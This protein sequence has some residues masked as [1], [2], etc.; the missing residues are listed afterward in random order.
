VISQHLVGLVLILYTQRRLVPY[1]SDVSTKTISAGVMGVGGNKGAVSVEFKFCQT[2]VS[3]VNCHLAAHQEKVKQRNQNLTKISKKLTL[4]SNEND[5]VVLMGDLNYRLAITDKS[6]VEQIIEKKDWSLLLANDQ[7]LQERSKGNILN[8]YREALI[9]FPPT[10]KFEVGTNHYETKKGRVPSWCDRI[11]WK[12]SHA[13]KDY[14]T[15]KKYSACME[16]KISD[17]KPVS[18]LL[19]IKASASADMDMLGKILIKQLVLEAKFAEN[20]SLNFKSYDSKRSRRRAQSQGQDDLNEVT[21]D[22]RSPNTNWRRSRRTLSET[23]GNIRNKM[24]NKEA[25]TQRSLGTKTTTPSSPET[26]PSTIQWLDTPRSTTGIRR[27][28][29]GEGHLRRWRTSHRSGISHNS[30]D[31]NKTQIERAASHNQRYSFSSRNNNVRRESAV[32]TS[33]FATAQS[34]QVWAT[35][36]LSL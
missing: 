30:A 24:L 28:T 31:E 35:N 12:S 22:L 16:Y 19:A 14:V 4:D 36:A 6:I 26:D 7:L 32:S 27:K 13:T 9:N 1:I 8:D 15:C 29:A 10:F 3:V 20:S 33:T 11:L 18:A 21:K 2:K 34:S 17:H 25:E 23:Q 5:V